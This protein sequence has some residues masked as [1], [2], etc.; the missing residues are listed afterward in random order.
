M[1][2]PRVAALMPAW[3][4]A[5]FIEATLASL[6]A[7]T[8]PALEI[9]VSDDASSDGTAGIC[10]RFAAADAR[11]RLLRQTTRRGWIGNTNALLRETRA[12]C[13][14]FAFHDD[15]LHPDYVARLVAA[16]TA[17]PRAVLAF[18]DIEVGPHIRSYTELD[19][20]TDRV[21]RGRRM[22][23]K[24][25]AWWIPNRGLF[26][27]VAAA[28]IGGVRRHLAGE[29]SA[30]WPWL[31][32]LALLGEFERVPAPLVRKV[33]WKGSV[34]DRWKGTPWQALGVALSAA[35]A[36]RAAGLAPGERA[37][38]YRE[39]AWRSGSGLWSRVRSTEA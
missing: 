10:E 20:V 9:I 29:Y 21:E 27:T 35:R 30:D 15:P 34:S 37:A 24:T 22:I 16:L 3:N 38:L 18:C 4:S 26:R 11:F 7:Q 25:G 19:G 39:L 14:F 28:R 2:V 5:A 12:D 33:Y 8:Y 1:S 6:Q 17:S 13:C 32:Q 36:I 31:L 23:R